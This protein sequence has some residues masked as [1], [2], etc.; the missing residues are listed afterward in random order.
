MDTGCFR[1][2]AVVN[3]AAVNPGVHVY[4]QIKISPDIYPGVGLQDHTVALFLA[5]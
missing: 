5:F 2:L 4:F 3:S 1:V